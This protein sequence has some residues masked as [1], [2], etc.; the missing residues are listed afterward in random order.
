MAD[1]YM[2]RLF[3]QSEEIAEH[4][5][6]EQKDAE[7]WVEKYRDEWKIRGAVEYQIVK[8][9]VIKQGGM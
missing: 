8:Y 5:F 1:Y 7:E 4:I 9:N 3:S 6:L 2:V